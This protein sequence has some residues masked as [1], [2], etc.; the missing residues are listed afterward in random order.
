MFDLAEIFDLKR[1]VFLFGI[2]DVEA[3]FAHSQTQ[4]P[5]LIQGNKLDIEMNKMVLEK[6]GELHNNKLNNI[7]KLQTEID[8]YYSNLD[9]LKLYE[10]L[11]NLRPRILFITSR[12]TTFLQYCI[13]DCVLACTNLNIPC[14][15][16]IE[17]SDIYRLS[18]LSILDKINEFKPDLIIMID[19]FAWE[20]PVVNNKII[21]I[22]W[23]Q[24]PLPQ[25]MDVNSPSKLGDLNFII[26]PY[27]SYKEF[28]ELGYPEGKIIK[29]TIP[30]NHRIYKY[31]KLNDEEINKY[32]TDITYIANGGNAYYGYESLITLVSS[33]DRQENDIIIKRLK[34]AFSMLYDVCRQG[35]Y[36]YSNQ[37]YMEILNKCLGGTLLSTLSDKEIEWMLYIFRFE[38]E[39]NMHISVP[40][41]W[42][43]ESKYKFKLWGKS[44]SDHPILSKYSMG[45]AS[46]GEEVSKIYNS[47]KIG[48]GLSPYISMHYRYFE[49][50]L[51]N[52]M[53]I[54]RSIPGDIDTSK[55]K[56]FFIE[57]KEMLLFDGKDDMFNKIDY[58]LNNSPKRSE[59]IEL[60]TASVLE[61]YTYEGFIRNILEMLVDRLRNIYKFDIEESADQKSF[62]NLHEQ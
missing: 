42:L 20:Y 18:S 32:S 14:D 16:L 43:D 25:I 10:R 38:I 17:E 9:L 11:K 62:Y 4:N 37:K 13:R 8:Y 40:L 27:T 57:N 50:I 28:D 35:K 26:S 15:L 30:V 41:E 55:I 47:S 31:Y 45:S 36:A 58:C 39:Y 5:S 34:D 48:L 1:L 21:F 59:I 53:Y 46:N 29:Y 24:D 60:G 23:I 7:V 12:F 56:S 49:V 54:G 6:M 22:T 19:H 61:K 2:N 3:W 52:C 33:R 51:S 44:W